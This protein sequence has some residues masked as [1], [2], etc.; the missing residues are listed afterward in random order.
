ML[1]QISIF[2]NLLNY[3]PSESLVTDRVIPELFTII[4]N[5][6]STNKKNQETSKT[7]FKYVRT[8]L[9]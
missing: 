3:V 1:L 5:N 4:N 2:V 7:L 9:T 6:P 8:N